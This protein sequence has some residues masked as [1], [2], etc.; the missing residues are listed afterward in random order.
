MEA[1]LDKGQRGPLVS[2]QASGLFH[3]FSPS[4][5]TPPRALCLPE[6]GGGAVGIIPPMAGS[7]ASFA[8][9][10]A[11]SLARGTHGGEGP[12]QPCLH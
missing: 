12:M 3:F 11:N 8:L 5:C 9:W 10:Q 2:S 7:T 4:S 6:G 1:N